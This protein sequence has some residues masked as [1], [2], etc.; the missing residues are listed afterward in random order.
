MNQVKFIVVE[1]VLFFP[2]LESDLCPDEIFA[3]SSFV[4]FRGLQD[5]PV[6]LAAAKRGPTNGM[7]FNFFI[8][9]KTLLSANTG[10]FVCK[11]NFAH[12]SLLS[13]NNNFYPKSITSFT[14]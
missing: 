4:W 14:K 3:K 7:C 6:A 13:A 11:N 10:D 9:K 2:R 8:T 5:H 12:K 1:N